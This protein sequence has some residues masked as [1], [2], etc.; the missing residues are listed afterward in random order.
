MSY[1]ETVQASELL[2]LCMTILWTSLSLNAVKSRSVMEIREEST[3]FAGDAYH[4]G[5]ETQICSSYNHP[6]SS[7]NWMSTWNEEY[8][9]L[10]CETFSV[11][12]WLLLEKNY[13][14]LEIVWS[15]F[16]CCTVYKSV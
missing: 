3:K 16:L 8:T 6:S 15:V 14:E 1:S 12:I 13:T 7:G 9:Y 10:V 2:F 11:G 4:S 5:Y